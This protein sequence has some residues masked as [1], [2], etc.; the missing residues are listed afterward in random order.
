VTDIWALPEER[1]YED[2]GTSPKGLGAGAAASL[3]QRH[4]KNV[5]PTKVGRPIA[6]K[7]LD[8][9]TSLFAIMLEVAAVLV[10]V[11]AM[12]STG[13]S[14]Q[15]NINVMIAIIAVVLLNAT[16]G[17]FQEYRAEKATEALRK[18]VPAN[19]K[20]IRDGDVAVIAAAALVLALLWYAGLA[21]A[22][23]AASAW[24][25]CVQY[26]GILYHY[27]SF[28][29][30]LIDTRDVVFYLT[31]TALSLFAAVGVVAVRRWR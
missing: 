23:Q 4:G 26:L 1:V 15:D 16:I 9:F 7:F 28:A 14:R 3:L 29:K 8:Q 2:L 22:N 13:A 21:T 5:L 18:L 11:A 20:V 30:G 17:F 27:Q 25:Q 31:A 12:L 10:L 19:A 6:F 24:T